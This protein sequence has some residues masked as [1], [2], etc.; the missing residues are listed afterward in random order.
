MPW[1]QGVFKNWGT[2]ES[3]LEMISLSSQLSRGWLNS[4]RV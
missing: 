4:L 1:L 3:A 2:M